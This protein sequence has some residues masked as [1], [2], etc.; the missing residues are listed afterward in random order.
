MRTSA[1]L[2]FFGITLL[3]CLGSVGMVI[4]AL[5]A[6][7]LETFL[8]LVMGVLGLPLA[9]LSVIVFGVLREYKISTPGHEKTT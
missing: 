6:T 2:S 1:Y 8:R 9:G 4:Y 5:L 3:I 7:N